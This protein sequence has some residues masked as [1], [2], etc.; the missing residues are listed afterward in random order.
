MKLINHKLILAALC[1]SVAGLTSCSDDEKY[2]I[3]GT[4]DVIA[5]LSPT[6]KQVYTNQVMRTAVGPLGAVRADIPVNI[7]KTTGQSVDVSAIADTTLVSKYNKE[8]NTDFKQF[9][10]KVLEKLTL[11]DAVIPAGEMKD[12]MKVSVP[13]DMLDQFTEPSYL[14]PVRIKCKGGNGIRESVDYNIA[15]IQV[16]TS[17]VT[18]FVHLDKNSIESNVINTPVG[19]FGGVDDQIKVSIQGAVS[20]DWTSTATVDNSLIAKYNEENKAEYKSLPDDVLKALT[21]TPEVIPAGET[22]A[23]QGIKVSIPVEKLKDLKDSYLVPLKVTSTYNGKTVAEDDDVVYLTIGV[24]ETLVNDNASAILGTK[25]TDHSGWTVKDCDNLDPEKFGDLFESGWGAGWT[26]QNK[27]ASAKFTIDLGKERKLTGFYLSSYVMN[28]CL[29]EVSTDGSNWVKLGNTSE[30]EPY[31]KW[32]PETYESLNAYVLYGAVGCRYLRFN[33]E[34]DEDSWAWR[35]SS[36]KKVT[37]FS[38]YF[39]D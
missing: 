25:A 28:N 26:F 32:D 29:V 39:G 30:H 38:L 7:Q 14:L 1:L 23:E 11:D 27:A 4:N 19:T 24:K 16:N 33:L 5:Y 37:D 35:Y 20:A 15:Y 22:A 8:N 21:I 6:V 3:D 12:T 2:D 34:L 36:Y 9:P 17:D 13:V 10:A 18:D 31:S